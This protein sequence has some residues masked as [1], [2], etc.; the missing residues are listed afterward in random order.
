VPELCLI[1][2][3]LTTHTYH[4]YHCRALRV[5]AMAGQHIVRPCR[6]QVASARAMAQL[7]GCLQSAMKTSLSHG[8][9]QARARS[10]AL[11]S[12]S[13]AAPRSGTSLRIA[14]QSLTA[15]YLPA[16]AAWPCMSAQQHHASCHS[17]SRTTAAGAAPSG[18][19]GPAAASG[20]RS[21]ASSVKLSAAQQ[22][23]LSTGL[24]KLQ[25]RGKTPA[26]AVATLE[27]QQAAAPKSGG[28]SAATAAPPQDFLIVNF[29]HLSDI[30]DP[31][32]VSDFE[33]MG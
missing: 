11:A 6:V 8:G 5:A 10:H 27:K 29:Y 25:R 16:R 9:L 19:G 28:E 1:V 17:S 13:A 4:S 31:D 22:R 2:G 33:R 21:A 14:S 24:P 7:G 32:E 26:A 12:T 15:G 20:R 30:A 23:A 18:D 3:A